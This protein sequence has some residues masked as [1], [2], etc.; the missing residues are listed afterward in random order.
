MIGRSVLMLAGTRRG[1]AFGA[2][3]GTVLPASLGSMPMT[4]LILAGMISCYVQ[5]YGLMRLR[6]AK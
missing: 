6:P 3:V 1:A 4:F 2:S 5:F